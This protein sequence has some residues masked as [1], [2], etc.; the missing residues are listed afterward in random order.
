MVDGGA[1]Y[2]PVVYSRLFGHELVDA[3]A[4]LAHASNPINVQ[5]EGDNRTYVPKHETVQTNE[6]CKLPV[7]FVYLSRP[8]PQT[9]WNGHRGENAIIIEE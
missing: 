7:A 2:L 5:F 3:R 6:F 4:A 8:A 9:S 1:T